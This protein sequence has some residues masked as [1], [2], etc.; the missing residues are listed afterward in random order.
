MNAPDASSAAL[1]PAYRS[2]SACSR[3]SSPWR[4]VTAPFATLALAASALAWDVVATG[5]DNPRG[6][7]FAPNGALYIAE[8]GLGGPG[9]TYVGPDGGLMYFGLSGS[10][11]RVRGGQ[12]QRIVSGLPSAAAIDGTGAIGPSDISFGHR[13]VVFLTVGLGR[14]PAVRDAILGDP[15]QLM[16]SLLRL[17]Q[18]GDVNQVADLAV[19]EQ[20]R[21]PDHNGP[22]TNPNGVLNLRGGDAYVTDAGANDLLH[23]S[24]SG[25][26]STIAVFPIAAQ[27]NR[28]PR[29]SPSVRMAR[30]ACANSPAR[31]SRS[32]GADLSRCARRSTHRLRRRFHQHH[33]PEI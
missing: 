32:A 8:A 3:V 30:S 11:T 33:R 20:T 2:I 27:C 9:P 24:A 21:D 31:P 5:L 7:D 14:P 26:I 4:V 16:G 28:C 18:D 15:A 19:Y 10:V 1:A 29:T 23:V 6:L 13:G 12:Q 17:S 25:K 22:D